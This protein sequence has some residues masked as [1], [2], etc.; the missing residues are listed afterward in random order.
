M[1]FQVSSSPDFKAPQGRRSN[2]HAYR[3]FQ[4]DSQTPGTRVRALSSLQQLVWKRAPLP[5]GCDHPPSV[6]VGTCGGSF[7]PLRPEC[8]FARCLSTAC[9][10]GC[11]RSQRSGYTRHVP[12]LGSCCPLVWCRRKTVLC[13]CSLLVSPRYRVHSGLSS[14][15]PVWSHNVKNE[16]KCSPKLKICL[17]PL[18]A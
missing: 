4:R 17:C 9:L 15:L 5:S 16:F 14:G 1:R 7:P 13:P 18:I 6:R 3:C 12:C 10:R 8:R 11:S 2:D